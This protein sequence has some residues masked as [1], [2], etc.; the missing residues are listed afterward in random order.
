M[1]KTIEKLTTQYPVIMVCGQRQTG[2][3]TML[4]HLAEPDRRY[5]TFDDAKT[6]ALAKNDPELFF[7]TFGTKL[8]IDEFQRVPEILIEIKKIVDEKNLC[9]GRSQWDVLAIG[10]PK[11][12][13]DEKHI[14]DASGQGRRIK[15]FTAVI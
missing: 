13:D 1:E 5:V 11:V 7:E 2:K 10:L 12:F 15:S 9:D 8:I 14:G 6:R 3:S 4:R